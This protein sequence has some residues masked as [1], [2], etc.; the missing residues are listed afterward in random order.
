MSIIQPRKKKTVEKN[1]KY[2]VHSSSPTLKPK[3]VSKT[4]SRRVFEVILL[5]NFST[6]YLIGDIVDIALTKISLLPRL[7]NYPAPKLDIRRNT[8]DDIVA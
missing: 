8:M 5:K 3:K 4:I 1:S 2:F 7:T 6:A